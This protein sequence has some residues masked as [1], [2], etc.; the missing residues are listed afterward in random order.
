MRAG[1]PVVATNVG[2]LSEVLDNGIDGVLI[3]RGDAAAL[4]AALAGLIGDASRRLQLGTAARLTYE[5]RFRL[6][7]MI[8]KTSAIYEMA[9]THDAAQ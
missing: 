3:P 6:E 7:Y 9:L 2:G 1:L 5:A 4:S 8:E